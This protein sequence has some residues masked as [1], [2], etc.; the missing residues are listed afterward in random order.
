MS[1]ATK[2]SH[3]SLNLAK[4]GETFGGTQ[5]S[6]NGKT[7]PVVRYCEVSVPTA[8][9]ASMIRWSSGRDTAASWNIRETREKYSEGSRS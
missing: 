2:P 9:H 3:E 1:E 4:A 7:V 8:S 6:G 5:S